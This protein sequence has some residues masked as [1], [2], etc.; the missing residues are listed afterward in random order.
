MRSFVLVVVVVV[1]VLLSLLLD[2]RLNIIR[3]FAQA[4]VAMTFMM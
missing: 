3:L 4:K 1:V 2:A